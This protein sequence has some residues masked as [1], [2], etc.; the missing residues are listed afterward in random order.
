MLE[1][2][3]EMINQLLKLKCLEST[4]VMTSVVL[5]FKNEPHQVE[6][7]KILDNKNYKRI[8]VAAPRNHSKSTCLS[9]N[10]PLQEIVR[11]C[12]IRILIVSNT[13]T[14]SQMHL[15]TI[16]AR[17]ERDKSYKEYAEDII[18]RYQDKWTEREIII[19]RTNLDLKD[20][21]VSTVG[22][23]GSILTR[24]ADVIICDDIL[25]PDNTRT[26]EQRK[27]VR[28]W[29]YEVLLP[30]LEPNGRLIVMGTIWHPD[31]LLSHLLEDPSYDF[32]TR[33]KAIINE[34]NNPKLWEEWSE[35]LKQNKRIEAKEFIEKNMVAMYDGTK[36][37]WETRFPY[38]KLYSL[39]K[40]NK[41]AF[42]KSYQNN[43]I[44]YEEQEIKNE[45]IQYYSYV[46]EEKV[47]VSGTGVDLAISKKETADYTAMVSGKL[48]DIGEKPKIYV[49]PNPVNSKLSQKETV[50]MAKSVSIALGVGNMTPLWVEDVA[51][52]KSAI[53]R[54]Q[55]MG[56]P[57]E[58]IRVSTDKRA[59]LKTISIYIENGTVLF[60]KTGCEDLVYQLIGF[61]QE[62]HDDLVDAFVIMVNA[63]MNMY[64]SGPKVTIF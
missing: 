6:W 61:G 51:Y 20:A 45:W 19:N 57:A 17:I 24:R 42:E 53:E 56:L 26:V 14:Q 8:V 62:A 25:G 46:E 10:F 37:L 11:D 39:R 44:S 43:V 31:D 35:L 50:E 29:F 23:G 5:G 33:Y 28:D 58:G 41:I 59:R 36:V 7:Y 4:D 15:R 1:E 32:R 30:V 34:S 21:T 52:Q 55:D 13:E 2:N 22:M 40:E 54:M 27:K 12:N 16:K 9:E 38:D 47:I 3:P 60:P 18:P 48:A 64:S 63:L 49:M